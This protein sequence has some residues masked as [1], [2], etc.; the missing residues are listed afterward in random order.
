MQMKRLIW[1]AGLLTA[2]AATAQD[3]FE[4]PEWTNTLIM[5]SCSSSLCFEPP[6]WAYPLMDEGRGR[7]PDDGTLLSVPGSDLQLTQTQIDDPFNPPDWYPDELPPMPQVVSHGRPPNVRACG[8]CH[9]L[10]GMGHPESSIMAGLPVNYVIR[11]MQ[12]YKSGDRTSLYRRHN[13]M[14]LSATHATDEEVRAA[15][16]YYVAIEPVKW[17][18]VIEAETVPETYVGPGNMRHPEPDGG[19]EPIGQR[20]IEIPEDSHLAERRDPHSP[21]IA[22]VPPGSIE[23]GLEL[24]TTGAGRTIQCYIC[25][26]DDLKGLGDVPG[27]AGMSPIYVARQL[28]DIQYGARTGTSA[29]LMLAV[30]ANLTY[31]DVIALSAYVASLDP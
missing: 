24:A 5:E 20:I 14:L 6:G 22:Y 3:D 27:I 15:A 12:D 29:A 19:T 23:A 10:H 9:M 8:Q 31:D 11:Q 25:H 13:S 28:W 17:V 7:G 21:F 2:Y 1:V 30:V 18:T 26:G 16:E 4:R